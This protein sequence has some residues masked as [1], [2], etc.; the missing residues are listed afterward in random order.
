MSRRD[1]FRDIAKSVPFDNSSNGFTSTDVQAAI[2][3]INNKVNT[4]A[5][6][7]F[8]FGRSGNTV[9]GT[10]LQNETVPSNVSGR[11][12]YINNAIVQR[13]FVSNELSTTYKIEILY[14]D[15]NEVGLTSLGTV[16]VT[17]AKGG[18]FSVNWSV[19]ANKQIAIR[20]AT[21]TPNA[22]KNIVC[23]LELS[24]TN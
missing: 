17:A 7:G 12:V 18:A 11:W 6:P 1:D 23:G 5:S 22:S 20:M 13:V 4:S 2:E 24:G 16:T 19:P 8:S 3:E 14:H 21:D 10:Y 15:G 9:A